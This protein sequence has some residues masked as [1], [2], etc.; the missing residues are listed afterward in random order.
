MYYWETMDASVRPE[1]VLEALRAAGLVKVRRIA[2]LGLF[3]EYEAAK[4]GGE[5]AA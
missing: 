1:T 2:L 5:S 4:P 3:S